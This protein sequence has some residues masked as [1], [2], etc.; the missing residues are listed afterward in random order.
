MLMSLEEL[1]CCF[2]RNSTHDCLL[3]EL[4]T[5]FPRWDAFIPFKTIYI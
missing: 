2:K 5:A 4:G 3:T 1:S